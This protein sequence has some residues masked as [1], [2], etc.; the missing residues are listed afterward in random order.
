VAIAMRCDQMRYSLYGRYGKGGQG[1]QG[2]SLGGIGEGRDKPAGIGQ[3]AAGGG[4]AGRLYVPR[5]ALSDTPH[6]H[7]PVR[8]GWRAWEGGS[9]C[10]YRYLGVLPKKPPSQPV[11]RLK[12]TGRR[13]GGVM[14]VVEG[15]WWK[16]HG[17]RKAVDLLME[18]ALGTIPTWKERCASHFVIAGFLGAS[19]TCLRH[20]DTHHE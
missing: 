7:P 17:G 9:G 2:C 12:E 5:G 13:E 20:Q 3:T 10:H 15:A 4:N 18:R 11:L 1:V 16:V 14:L 6:T 8:H 19:D